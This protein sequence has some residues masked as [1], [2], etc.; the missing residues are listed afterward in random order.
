MPSRRGSGFDLDLDL[1]TQTSSLLSH[2]SFWAEPGQSPAGLVP[3]RPLRLV[4]S[5]LA[6]STPLR[7]QPP[8]QGRSRVP[9]WQVQRWP[10]LELQPDSPHSPQPSMAVVLAELRQ[11]TAPVQH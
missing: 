6:D 8:H 11:R 10:R 3:R 7:A 5:A 9:W 4:R 2:R 1:T